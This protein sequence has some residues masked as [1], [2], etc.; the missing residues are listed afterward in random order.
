MTAIF[1]SRVFNKVIYKFSLI[2][3]AIYYIVFSQK[4]LSRH[5]FFLLGISILTATGIAGIGYIINDLKDYEQDRIANKRN[6]F[7]GKNLFF[8]ISLILSCICIAIFPWFFLPSTIYTFLLLSIELLLFLI[9]AAPPFR[10]KE[11]GFSGII[12]DALY[13]QVIPC[14]LAAYTFTLIGNSKNISSSIVLTYT[15]WLLVTGIRNIICHQIDDFENDVSS[16][17][18]TFVRNIGVENAQKLTFP[19]LFFVEILLFIL[20]LIFLHF[21][22]QIPLLLFLLYVLLIVLMRYLKRNKNETKH[23]LY[24][25]VNEK[26]LNEFY[27]I[28]LPVLLLLYYA[29]YDRQFILLLM[30]HLMLFSGIY[31]AYGKGFYH[32]Y[33]A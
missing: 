30:L 7:V 15:L 14:L 31:Y 19:Y 17:T 20:L 5:T 12:C 26:I 11:K 13:A 3:S 18:I 1:R 10:L 4:T 8:K 23:Q 2:F 28:Q 25:F 32:K 33:I 27:E 9:Y 21:N 6:L 29:Y 24:H 16:Y 22:F